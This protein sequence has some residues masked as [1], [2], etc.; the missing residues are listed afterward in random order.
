ME[1]RNLNNDK[2][3]NSLY[4]KIWFRKIVMGLGISVLFFVIFILGIKIG[5]RKAF[6]AQD[7]YRAYHRNFIGPDF[8]RR[9]GNFPL[10]RPDFLKDNFLNP[11]GILGKILKNDINNSELIIKDKD[12]IEKVIKIDEKTFIV[13]FRSLIKQG[14]LKEGDEIIVI[15]Q[16]QENGQI[17]AKFIRV[18][19]DFNK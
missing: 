14:D 9:Q 5:E 12:N 7:W 17:L 19:P 4:K 15:G 3:F 11:H 16:P 1:E 8:I 18:F 2:N 13:S 6:F 10:P